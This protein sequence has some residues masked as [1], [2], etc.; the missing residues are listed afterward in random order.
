MLP[1]RV[2]QAARWVS[3]VVEVRNER[4]AG[5]GMPGGSLGPMGLRVQGHNLQA[6]PD[7]SR[8]SQGVL[9]RSPVQLNL[10]RGVC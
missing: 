10:H 3:R 9:S 4:V 6:T 7:R 1:A 5:H 2:Y 8:R